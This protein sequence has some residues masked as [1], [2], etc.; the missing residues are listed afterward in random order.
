MN[1]ALNSKI[2]PP[3]ITPPKSTVNPFTVAPGKVQLPYL[4]NNTTTTPAPTQ[5]TNK[6]ANM[7][8]AEM[9]A[10]L[11]NKNATAASPAVTKPA[12]TTS[13]SSGPATYKGVAI[14]PGSD[15]D[16]S[17]QIARIDAQSAPKPVTTQTP[18]VPQ[19]QTQPQQPTNL[20]GSLIG[21][22]TG[23]A[24]GN[25]QTSQIATDLQNVGTGG[26][27]PKAIQ[28]L[29]DLRNQYAEKIAGIESQP[30]PLE[31]QQGQAGVLQ[32]LMAARELALQQ[33]VG[34]TL[35]GQGQQI[36]A[37]SSAGGITNTQQGL[38]QQALQQAGALAAPI[39]VPYTNQLLNPAT[40]A[41]V[42]GGGTNSILNPLNSIQSYAQMV[43]SGQMSPS[44]A[45]SALG[46]NPAF[47]A[48]LNQAI[49]QQNPNF[50]FPQAEANATAQGQALT[51]NVQMGGQL[52]KQAE[53]VKQHMQT[54]QTAYE[55]LAANYG[56]PLLNAG[57]NAV[58]SQFGS[59]P[60]QSYKL[61][62]SNVRDE[63][64][65]VLGGGSAT[66]GTRITA[67]EVLPDNMTP[68]QIK[69]AISTAT[70]LMNAK[71]AEF[72]TPGNVP[73]YGG[74]SSSTGGSIWDF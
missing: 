67:Q 13:A 18:T 66:E 33:A 6:Y 25:P 12:A 62:L 42:Q 5:S 44:Q 16:I 23:Q 74:G 60:L 55:Q 35:E 71:I 39:Q 56:L 46:N 24:L 41:N 27:L 34:N 69:S 20:Y 68:A 11:Q 49:S 73:Q 59:G 26:E 50:N 37:L 58:A 61:A 72:T 14:T 48:A 19:T 38:I 57:V 53:T 54:L 9:T 65:K 7:S 21:A 10:Y 31:F 52:Q 15:F 28:A 17:Q 29:A 40:G 47:T 36:T 51:Q 45:A 3:T 70:E 30:I 22:L 4:G 43:V 1:L 2:N 8:D 64:A 32:R 63:L